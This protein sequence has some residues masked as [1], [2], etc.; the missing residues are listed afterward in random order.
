M[1]NKSGVSY[2][3]FHDQQCGPLLQLFML[4]MTNHFFDG[5][6]WVVQLIS[7]YIIFDSPCHWIMSAFLYPQQVS[8]TESTNQGQLTV[9]LSKKC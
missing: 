6:R 3:R 1:E 9:T 5:C 8:E 4:Y 2:T 7:E